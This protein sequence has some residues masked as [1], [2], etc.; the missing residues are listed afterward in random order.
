M[1]CEYYIPL[2]YDV[3]CKRV[4]CA[5]FNAINVNK[6]EANLFADKPAGMIGK[7]GIL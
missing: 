1:I 6:A 7:S 2:L 3:L 4:E 5:L